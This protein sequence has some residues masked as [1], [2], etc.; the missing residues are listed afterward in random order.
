MEDASMFEAFAVVMRMV[1]VLDAVTMIELVISTFDVVTSDELA[2]C[3]CQ[4]CWERTGGMLR[5]TALESWRTTI[6]IP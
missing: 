1:T 4:C 5:F 3:M 6:F 2:V